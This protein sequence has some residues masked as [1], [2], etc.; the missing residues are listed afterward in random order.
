MLFNMC[1]VFMMVI[2]ILCIYYIVIYTIEKIG[3][4]KDICT[5]PSV[6]NC[7]A[8]YPEWDS[9]GNHLIGLE[10]VEKI[11]Q[12]SSM[13]GDQ[14]AY[15]IEQWWRSSEQEDFSWVKLQAAITNTAQEKYGRT[16]RSHGYSF[17]D[18]ILPE[19]CKSNVNMFK[20]M[21]EYSKQSS[22]KNYVPFIACETD[23]EVQELQEKFEDLQVEIMVELD[24]EHLNLRNFKFKLS[25]AK[26][27]PDYFSY[28]QSVLLSKP[29]LKTVDE[30]FLRIGECWSFLD[31]GLLDIII[32]KFGS[33]NL[34]HRMKIYASDLGKFRI[35]T[36]VAPFVRALKMRNLHPRK[37]K[38][39]VF[40]KLIE[41]IQENPNSCTLAHL[42]VLRTQHFDKLRELSLAQ[43]ALMVYDRVEL[44][45]VRITWLLLS[46]QVEMFEQMFEAC[47][48]EG[49]T[50]FYENA[51]IR[52]EL[53]GHIFMTMERV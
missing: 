33:E 4:R 34:K 30:F 29:S 8:D 41:T 16:F 51:I 47:I 18:S 52:V 24:N 22:R 11:K 3:R 31:Y 39:A 44:C 53:D 37:P 28:L 40:E 9:I 23:T 42:E 19:D 7:V 12:D 6:L 1:I 26:H 38:D 48:M 46:E 36:K 50:F 2:H 15:M 35:N 43:T 25:S 10:E 21:L 27:C 49:G 5:R 20:E 17:S 13:N 45:C 32:R 14:A